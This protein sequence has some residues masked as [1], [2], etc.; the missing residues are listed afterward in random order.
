MAGVWI[1]TTY[2]TNLIGSTQ[3]LA[4]APDDTVF[5]QHFTPFRPGDDGYERAWAENVGKLAKD[6]VARE[7]AREAK[8]KHP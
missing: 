8:L 3:R 2:V 6:P 5:D 1:T 4:V 7:I